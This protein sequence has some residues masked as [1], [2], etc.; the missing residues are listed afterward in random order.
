M[1]SLAILEAD[2]L[3]SPA[4]QTLAPP[5]EYCLGDF[6]DVPIGQGRAFQVGS[7]TIAVFRQRNGRFYAI[8]NECPHRGGPLSEGLLG[9]GT[10]ICP[11][12]AWKV[13][14][15]TGEC[16][17]DPCR[18]RTYSVREENGLILLSLP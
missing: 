4:A 8:Q 10:V 18:I 9:N 7:E 1:S 16:L 13:D 14:V 6:N 17:T 2:W 12:H 11:F 5:K 15:A 3:D